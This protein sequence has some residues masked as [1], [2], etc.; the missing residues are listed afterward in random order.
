M[1]DREDSCDNRG[2]DD[3]NCSDEDSD[4]EGG[5]MKAAFSVEDLLGDVDNNDDEEE[6]DEERKVA[7]SQSIASQSDSAIDVVDHN[8]DETDDSKSGRISLQ[9]NCHDGED[10]EARQRCEDAEDISKG[11]DS[12]SGD[13]D[14]SLGGQGASKIAR[15]E[16]D[17]YENADETIRE[18]KRTSHGSDSEEPKTLNSIDDCAEDYY[19]NVGEKRTRLDLQTERGYEAVYDDVPEEDAEQKGG[20]LVPGKHFLV[21]KVDRQVVV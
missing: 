15:E 1:S 21:A 9:N 4:E 12:P 14:R 11:S 16:D 8:G 7:L 19:E 18:R 13:L 10:S 5:G 2:D 3:R 6:N 17:I 20:T